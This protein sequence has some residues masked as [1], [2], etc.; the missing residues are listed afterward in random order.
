MKKRIIC[1]IVLIGCLLGI[2]V[3]ADTIEMEITTPSISQSRIAPERDF[4]VIGKLN[5]TVP[6]DATLSVELYKA[7]VATPIRV[8]ETRGKSN[9]SMNVNY[10]L[11]SYYASDDRTPLYSAMM[12]DLVY[13]AEDSS[14]IQAIWNKAYF[15]DRTFTALLAGGEYSTDINLTDKNGQQIEK[16]KSGQYLLVVTMRDTN[17]NIQGKTQKNITIAHAKDRMLARFSPSNHFENIKEFSEQHGYELFLDPFPGYWSPSNYIPELSGSP[18]FAEILPKWRLADAQEYQSGVA[19][20][21]IYNVSDTSA[22]YN[23]EVGTLQYQG[24]INDNKRMQSYYYS[25][26]EPLLPNGVKS[27]IVKFDQG[28]KLQITR[29]DNTGQLSVKDNYMDAN[30][31]NQLVSYDI[32]MTDGTVIHDGDKLSFN[33][34]VTPI[35]NSLSDIEKRGNGTYVMKNKI[36]SVDY[37]IVDTVSGTVYASQSKNVGIDRM[38]DNKVRN[39]IFEFRHEVQFPKGLVGKN[40][41]VLIEAKDIYGQTVS[42]TQEK[43]PVEVLQ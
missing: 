41:S 30:T 35:Q 16:L 36:L 21:V 29:V 23:V 1:Y 18:I 19:H 39:S 26:G 38:I 32:D 34:V 42:G 43:I 11:L 27:T 2:H 24:V 12:P 31:F 13:D 8:V 7:G 22:T 3:A 9:Q 28:D 40:I 17:G 5:G 6:Q 10:P 33:G 37:K 4:Y 14:S 25:F 15:T 20:F